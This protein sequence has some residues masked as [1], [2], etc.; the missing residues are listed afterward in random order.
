[1]TTMP[2]SPSVEVFDALHELLMLF[3]ARMR[4]RLEAVNPE[5]TF[6][7]LRV[8]MYVGQRPGC[9]QK[10]LVEHSRIDKAQ[11]ARI[12]AQL[13]GKGWLTR[14]ESPD[15]RRVR[16]LRLSGQGL[17]LFRQLSAQRA[18][19]AAEL[20]QGCPAVVQA[21]LLALLGQ[22]LESARQP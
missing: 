5:L 3:R 14:C 6:G 2:V 8:L 9:A 10:E 18:A 15:D 17:G 20:L 22:A 7:E 21:Q 4:Q 12:V 16:Q 13:E 11:M 19:L 1:M